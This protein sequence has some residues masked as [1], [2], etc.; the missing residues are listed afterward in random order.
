MITFCVT[1]KISIDMGH[2]F[3]MITHGR[4][5]AENDNIIVFLSNFLSAPTPVSV[6][7]RQIGLSL[8]K[9]CPQLE[10][11]LLSALCNNTLS[12]LTKFFPFPH[13][14]VVAACGSAHTTKYFSISRSTVKVVSKE[15]STTTRNR[16]N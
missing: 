7:P 4:G 9:F 15:H 14:D 13:F 10:Q 8:T 5:K 12:V 3:K 6:G 11:N 16:E 2:P 1:K